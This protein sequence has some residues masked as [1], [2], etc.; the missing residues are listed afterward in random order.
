MI[1]YHKTIKIILIL[2]AINNKIKTISNNITKK[3]SHGLRKHHSHQ[4]LGIIHS[5]YF[6]LIFIK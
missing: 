2:I 6:L 1:I 4:T 5:S 3:T